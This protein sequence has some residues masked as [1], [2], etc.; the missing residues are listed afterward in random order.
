M[1]ARIYVE[2][3]VEIEVNHLPGEESTLSDPGCSEEF[4]LMSFS[5]EQ[6]VESVEDAVDNLSENEI[7]FAGLEALEQY[8]EEVET[9]RAEAAFE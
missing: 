9:D 3:P 2:I 1:K 8:T 5:K 6:A 4:E 7:Y